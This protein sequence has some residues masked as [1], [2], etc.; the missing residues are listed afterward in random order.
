MTTDTSEQMVAKNI[1][2][3]GQGLGSVFSELQR[4]LIELQMVWQQYRQLYGTDDATVQLLNRTAGLLFMVVQDQLWDSVL[5]AASRLTDPAQTNGNKNL[6]IFSLVPLIEDDDLRRRV[7][8]SCNDALSAAKFARTQRNKRIAHQDFSHAM[9]R[10]ANPMEGGSRQQVEDLL[11]SLRAVFSLLDLHYRD[12]TTLYGE[13]HDQSGAWVLIA[14][15]KRLE[16]LS[17]SAPTEGYDLGGG[18]VNQK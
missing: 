7:E 18:H 8:E 17:A 11:A 10:A 3:M 2:A 4:K 15:L 13:F 6:S 14:K 12:S 5:L 16:R 1:A 9:R